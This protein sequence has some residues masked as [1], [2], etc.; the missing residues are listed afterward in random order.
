MSQSLDDRSHSCAKNYRF[1]NDRIMQYATTRCPL[2][3]PTV[4]FRRQVFEKGY[5]YNPDAY[6]TE[7]FELW[8]WLLLADFKFANT[9]EI[10]LKF[11]MSTETL[12][13]RRGVAKSW[14]EFY[15]CFKFMLRS[16]NVSIK[17]IIIIFAKFGLQ[18]MSTFVIKLYY[19]YFR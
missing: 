13:R 3:H 4:M 15:T 1:S 19:A 16:R 11:K 17:N 2:V 8:H 14:S 18:M 5:R 7:D 9:R 6:L 12:T 10:L